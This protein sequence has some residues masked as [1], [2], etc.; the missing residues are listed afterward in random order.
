MGFLV[1]YLLFWVFIGGLIGSAIGGSKGRG[2]AGFWLGALLGFI[3]WIIVAV[4]EPTDEVRRARQAETI[5][6]ATGMSASGSPTTRGATRACPWC[7]EDIKPAARVCRYCGRDVEPVEVSVEQ[8]PA[9]QRESESVNLVQRLLDERGIHA[10]GAAI[11]L[12]GHVS[13]TL[14]GVARIGAE[15]EDGV[16]AVAG[17][18]GTIWWKD[19]NEVESVDL[20]AFRDVERDGRLLTLRAPDHAPIIVLASDDHYAKGW[21]QHLRRL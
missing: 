15:G 11:A 1:G 18:N 6:L 5:A 12:N 7:A 21:L 20:R 17:R 13:A 8:L 9:M 16:I 2:T 10:P 14:D 4:M 19:R 3:G